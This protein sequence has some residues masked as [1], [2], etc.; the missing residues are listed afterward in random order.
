MS[1]HFEL[2]SKS[3][4]RDLPL[5]SKACTV[6]L[7]MRISIELHMARLQ[8]FGAILMQRS[9]AGN[10]LDDIRLLFEGVDWLQG[11]YPIDRSGYGWTAFSQAVAAAL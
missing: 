10:F 5:L 6:P 7:L 8:S 1:P 3:S 2:N 9:Y 11:R 4:C